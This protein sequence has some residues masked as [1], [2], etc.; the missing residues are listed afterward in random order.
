[1]ALNTAYQQYLDSQVMTASKGKLLLLTYDGAIRFLR[2]AQGHMAARS[3]EQQNACLAKAQRI[4]LELIYT[5]DTKVDPDLAHRLT[6]LY[7]YMFNRL[8]EA[9][10]HDNSEA[11]DEVL[12]HLNGLREAWADADRQLTM[13]PAESGSEHAVAFA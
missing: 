9:N 6:L 12:G 10:V 1:M 13:A 4:I 7:E 3:F 11:L 2:Q 5:L 8:I